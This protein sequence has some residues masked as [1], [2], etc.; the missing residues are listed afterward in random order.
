MSGIL[1]LHVVREAFMCGDAV[2]LIV[3]LDRAVCHF[4]IHLFLGVLIRTG[5]AILL[6]YYM[7]VKFYSPVVN[8][9]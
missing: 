8:P 4:Q 9:V 2:T 6:V 7:K 1:V 5:I 3:D